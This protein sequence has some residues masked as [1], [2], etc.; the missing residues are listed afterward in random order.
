MPCWTRE[1]LESWLPQAGFEK[2]NYFGA[3]DAGI[4]A[5]ATDRLVVVAQL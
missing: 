5:G 4:A 3:Y 1:E 2:V